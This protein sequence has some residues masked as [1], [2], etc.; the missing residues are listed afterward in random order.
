LR[1]LFTFSR[2][3]PKTAFV[4][5]LQRALTYR[6]AELET[7]KR[8]AWFCMNQGEQRLPD[9]DVD[10]NYRERPAYQEGCLTDEPDLSQYDLDD[11]L[12]DNDSVTPDESEEEDA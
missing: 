8:I 7:V 6:V 2:Q 1:A 9:V 5:A 10:E 4:Q 12:Q 3:V 11:P